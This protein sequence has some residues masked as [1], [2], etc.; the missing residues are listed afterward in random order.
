MLFIVCSGGI[1]YGRVAAPFSATL[2]TDVIKQALF[3]RERLYQIGIN[4]TITQADR[5]QLTGGDERRRPTT[6]GG[7]AAMT[8][9]NICLTPVRK[10]EGYHLVAAN[11]ALYI[12]ENFFSIG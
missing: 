10:E 5:D 11:F 8:C 6:A 7:H 3:E 12:G 2:T 9:H 4:R 1:L